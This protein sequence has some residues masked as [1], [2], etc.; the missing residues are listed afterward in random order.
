[1]N[2][3]PLDT[4]LLCCIIVNKATSI[5]LKNIQAGI[6]NYVVLDDINQIQPKFTKLSQSVRKVYTAQLNRNHE[7]S[8]LWKTMWL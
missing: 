8:V 6:I 5:M 3:I 4:K 7:E 2:V 1:M